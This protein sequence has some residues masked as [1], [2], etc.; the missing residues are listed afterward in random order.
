MMINGSADAEESVTGSR[1]GFDSTNSDGNGNG[2]DGEIARF[3]QDVVAEVAHSQRAAIGRNGSSEA[4]DSERLASLDA[5]SITNPSETPAGVQ[6]PAPFCRPLPMRYEYHLVP[7]LPSVQC[8]DDCYRLS[9][10]KIPCERKA[11]KYAQAVAG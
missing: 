2:Q 6:L 7:M 9:T 10:V 5:V 4:F 8:L 11:H 1:T 3:L